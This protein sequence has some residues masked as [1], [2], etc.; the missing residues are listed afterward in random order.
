MSAE[1]ERQIPGQLVLLQ[2]KPW[3]S[4]AYGVETEVCALTLRGLHRT[5]RWN[6]VILLSRYQTRNWF[7]DAITLFAPGLASVLS[8]LTIQT[9]YFHYNLARKYQRLF[10]S[11]LSWILAPCSYFGAQVL[12]VAALRFRVP[13]T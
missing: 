12:I 1:R 9:H 2:V 4:L 13:R 6:N 5:S 8:C 3:R 10:M 11:C 7:R